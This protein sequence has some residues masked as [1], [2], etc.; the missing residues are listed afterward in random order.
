MNELGIHIEAIYPTA[1]MKNLV[2]QQPSWNPAAIAFLE[3]MNTKT[4]RWKQNSTKLILM[5][6]DAPK[7]AD[8]PPD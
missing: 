5:M 8:D 1:T 6:F 4:K 3:R 7:H 2:A